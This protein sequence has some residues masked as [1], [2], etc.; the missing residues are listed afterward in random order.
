[1][2]TKPHRLVTRR[3]GKNAFTLIE[4]LVVIAII[5]IL[6]AL[7]LPALAKAKEKALRT[8][9]LS[10]MRQIGIATYNYATESDDRLPELRGSAAWAWD[11][12]VPAGNAMLAA[13]LT[14][15]TFYCPGTRPRFTDKENWATVG[16]G[17]GYSQWYFGVSANPPRDTDFYV[18]GYALAFWGA[19]CMLQPTN[20]NKKITAE[21]P[22]GWSRVIGPSDREMFVDCTLSVNQTLPG[23]TNPNN[24]YTSVPG[25][26]TQNGQVYPHI[27]A[28]V[29]GTTPTGGNVGFKDGHVEW[30]KFRFMV[31]RTAAGRV[32]WW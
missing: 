23:Y 12:P 11:L 31:P 32:F 10:N 6:A 29:K 3:N 14:K 7:L 8:Q 20:Q 15:A 19:N 16:I 26:F 1:M 17:N 27:S 24:N 5:A 25:G 30:R 2:K 21:A 9:C 18:I 13:G 28:H 22:V 4:L